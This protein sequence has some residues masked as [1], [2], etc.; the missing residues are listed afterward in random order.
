MSKDSQ[1][2]LLQAAAEVIV[3][4]IVAEI[5]QAGMFSIIA[6]EARDCSHSEQLS[7]CLRYVHETAI[8]ERFLT[9]VH[10]IDLSA[11]GL[12]TVIAKTLSTMV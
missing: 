1:N 8:K 3:K 2:E 5:Q 10:V 6:D 9:F 11:A 12:A 4:Q 7:I